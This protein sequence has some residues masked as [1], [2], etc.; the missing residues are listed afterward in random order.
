MQIDSERLEGV[1]VMLNGSEEDGYSFFPQGKKESQGSWYV[2]GTGL[3]RLGAK[4]DDG[5]AD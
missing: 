4:P 2:S 5:D 1:R 3:G